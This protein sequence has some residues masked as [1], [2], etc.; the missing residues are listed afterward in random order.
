MHGGRGVTILEPAS[1]VSALDEAI[2]TGAVIRDR[3]RALVED[4]ARVKRGVSRR[5]RQ[6]SSRRI[7]RIATGN[8]NVF[9]TKSEGQGVDTACVL[10]GD[11]SGSMGYDRRMPMLRASV[12]SM[13]SASAFQI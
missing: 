4:R 13:A 12:F 3:M 2:E 10:L 9:R 8:P 6:I 1:G 11:I 5:G 7:S